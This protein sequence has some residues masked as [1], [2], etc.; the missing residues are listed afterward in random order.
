[1]RTANQYLLKS[2][3]IHLKSLRRL[4]ALSSIMSQR[5][6]NTSNSSPFATG[7]TPTSLKAIRRILLCI[8]SNHLHPKSFLEAWLSS[9]DPVISKSKR[10]WASTGDGIQSTGRLLCKIRDTLLKQKFGREFWHDW[11][12]SEVSELLI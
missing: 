7:A 10:S 5:T 2:D 9:N 8:K 1:M 3:L 12:L 11:I 6:Q 4:V